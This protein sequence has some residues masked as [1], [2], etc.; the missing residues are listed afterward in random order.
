MKLLGI[1]NCSPD[2]FSGDGT[3]DHNVAF[4]QAQRM[5]AD[6]A[7]MVDVG[8]SSTRPGAVPISADE[9]LRRIEPLIAL[10]AANHIPFSVDTLH[11]ETM[12]F[13]IRCGAAMINDQRAL[14]ES[15]TLEV[16]A[17]SNVLVC[18]MHTSS[19]DA[20]TL[21]LPLRTSMPDGYPWFPILQFFDKRTEV[22]E[23]AGI[24]RDRI[25]LD[26]GFGFGKTFHQQATILRYL[27]RLK[28]TFGCQ[29]L[30]GLS[31]KR[32]I[33]SLGGAPDVADRLTPAIV[34]GTLA[35]EY[36]ADILRVHDVAAHDAALRS[37]FHH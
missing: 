27:E 21:H 1:L 18:L 2:S 35:A 23:K 32:W 3:N 37:Y 24:K 11:A 5:M 6:G 31:R 9:E 8:A 33:G 29:V 7:W 36:G 15:G 30:V 12:D 19:I 25:I 14:Q 16:V 4:K 20:H 28:A 22:C 10:L 34:V 17:D 13:A 26:P